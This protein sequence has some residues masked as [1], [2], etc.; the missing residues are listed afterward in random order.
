L[1]RDGRYAAVD[2]RD[3]DD[4]DDDDGLARYCISLGL[5][6]VILHLTCKERH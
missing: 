4:D 3:L 2:L 5:R 6:H 1:L